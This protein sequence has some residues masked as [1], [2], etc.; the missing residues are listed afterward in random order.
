MQA[1]L[2]KM[3]FG[4]LYSLATAVAFL[5]LFSGSPAVA[6]GEGEAFIVLPGEPTRY[7]GQKGREGD[8]TELLAT[9][10]R[11]GG[12]LG[13]FRQTIAP[14][15]GPPTHLHEMEAEFCYVVSGQFNFK[16]GERIVSAPAG[17]FVFIPRITPH[18][19]QNIGTEP[20]VLLFGVAPGGFEM[21]F[22]ERQGVDAD[23]NQKLMAK[24]HMQVVGPPLR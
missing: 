2:M 10:D 6:A 18:T 17:A 11:T 20:G 3:G 12:V 24:H 13:F 15:S 5:V 21:M 23:T 1:N 19:F 8:F 7:T 16:L 14:K 4:L 22:A 9:A